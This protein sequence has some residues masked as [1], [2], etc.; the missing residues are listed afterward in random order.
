MIDFKILLG[1]RDTSIYSVVRKVRN[2]IVF[3]NKY[4]RN[5]SDDHVIIVIKK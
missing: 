4:T 3:E 1:Y 5:K 2:D